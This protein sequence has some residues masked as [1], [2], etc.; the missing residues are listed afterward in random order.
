[1]K[2]TLML[3]GTMLFLAA[4]LVACGGRPEPTAAP[5]VAPTAEAK[6]TVEVPNLTAWES[7]AHNAVDTEPFRHWDDATENT[8]G[9]P[10]ACARCHTSAGY[11]DFLGADGSAP[12]VVDK[13]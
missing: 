4:I 11:Q 2:K 3:L 7:S 8:D 12:D 9:V 1:M 5:T 13:A 10:V 6:P